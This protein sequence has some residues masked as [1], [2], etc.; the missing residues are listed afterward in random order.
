M[1]LIEKRENQCKYVA[2]LVCIVGLRPYSLS[3]AL[4]QCH[5]YFMFN[6]SDI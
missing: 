5:N 2:L 3:E 1:S 6:F 4:R